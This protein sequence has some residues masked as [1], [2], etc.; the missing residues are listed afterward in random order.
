M[1]K[2]QF[3]EIYIELLDEGT[4]CSRP[5]QGRRISDFKYFV[6]PTKDYD[7]EDEKW[8][9]LPGTFVRCEWVETADK[10]GGKETILLAKEALPDPKSETKVELEELRKF[11]IEK[12]FIKQLTDNIAASGKKE[13]IE[14]NNLNSQ[15][16]E[17]K[18]NRIQKQGFLLFKIV[19]LL[20]IVFYSTIFIAAV[21]IIFETIF[22]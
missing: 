7:P 12:E 14:N 4:P 10:P 11:H 6:M 21:I 8:R 15:L 13:S 17:A 22:K 2:D 20:K 16:N 3:D 1:P 19:S 9:F 5:T 18:V